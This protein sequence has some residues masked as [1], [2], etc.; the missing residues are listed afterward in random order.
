M[1]VASVTLA[2][3]RFLAVA[4][5]R[6]VD[7]AAVHARFVSQFAC[8]APRRQHNRL[9]WPRTIGDAYLAAMRGYVLAEKGFPDM[10]CTEVVLHGSSGIV[11]MFASTAGRRKCC[12]KMTTTAWS[13]PSGL[14]RCHHVVPHV[15]HA[16][17]MLQLMLA[18]DSDV[19]EESSAM[20]FVVA[21]EPTSKEA[22]HTPRAEHAATYLEVCGFLLASVRELFENDVVMIDL[23]LEN[24]LRT[25]NEPTGVRHYL[26]DVESL[27]ELIGLASAN[28]QKLTYACCS[29]AL[30]SR[31]LDVLSTM[32]A[33]CCSAFDLANAMSHP[34]DA[35][36]LEPATAATQCRA[37]GPQ[38][39]LVLAEPPPMAMLWSRVL[40]AL[41]DPTHVWGNK[42]CDKAVSLAIL[43][44]ADDDLAELRA[45]FALER[46]L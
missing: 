36:S 27:D 45:H 43:S 19:W 42:V 37:F 21:E 39:P 33:M 18:G 31:R 25:A 8:R 11:F 1:E 28:D 24:I 14:R 15:L 9:V 2:A 44:A 7:A 23:K 40:R 38:H 3:L 35:V 34:R 13:P 10:A 17:G 26:C 4:C 46:R 41:A 20:E 12:V 5:R 32:F 22:L 30:A 29:S 16:R 6:P